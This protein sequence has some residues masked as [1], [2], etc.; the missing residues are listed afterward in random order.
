MRQLFSDIGQQAV[1]TEIP[2][3]RHIQEDKPHG[4]SGSLQEAGDQ[5]EITAPGCIH[6]VMA[7]QLLQGKH[8]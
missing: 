4:Y 5:A 3:N 8:R 1:Q 2:E 6:K 7:Q